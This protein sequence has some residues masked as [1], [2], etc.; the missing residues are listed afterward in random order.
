LQGT[1][2]LVVEDDFLILTELESTL[3]EAGA[4]IAGTCRTV[5]E[6]LALAREQELDAALL[7]L[8]VGHDAITPV[9][10]CL[11][12]QRV[13]FAFYTGQT[14]TDPIR[15]QWPDCAIVPK[16]ATSQAIV[17]AVAGLLNRPRRT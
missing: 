12:Q 17:A 6:A 2:I 10:R 5:E 13:P 16:P 11:D 15:A 4:R 7:D 3:E 14:E 9:A 8:R 1:R